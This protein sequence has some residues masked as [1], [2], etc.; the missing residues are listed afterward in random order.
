MAGGERLFRM[1]DQ[2]PEW[3]DAPAA[4]PLPARHAAASNSRSVNFEYEPGRP[5]LTRHFL[6]GRA[7]PN[8]RAGRPHRQRQNDHRGPAAE[9]LPALARPRAHRR[10][11]LLDV[12]SDSLHAQMG[13]V[14]QN[15]FLFSG[16][17]I[18]NIRFARP[19]ATEADVR[20]TLRALD[21][22][23]LIEALPNGLHTQVGENGARRFR[24]ASGNWSAL[25]GPCW[26]TR[27]SWCWTRRP[28]RSTRVTETRLQRALEILV[29]RPH[30]LRR[31]APLEHHPQSG[32]GAGAGPG[33]HRR[34]RHPRDPAARRR[35]LRPPARRI[36]RRTRHSLLSQNL[37]ARS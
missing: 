20:E 19:E 31:G 36:H 11:D 25:R 17:V 15:N 9:I 2:E 27:A 35:R 18:D 10:S 13:S 32:F 37:D 22:L 21:C 23:D 26:P 33:P 28:A 4:K 24:W 14:Q 6:C 1:L 12:T 8:R 30:G 3:R 29:A 34:T 5:V 7:G 16:S